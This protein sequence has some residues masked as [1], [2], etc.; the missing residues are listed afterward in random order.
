[1]ILDSFTQYKSIF[2]I[3]YSDAFEIWDRAGEIARRL[4]D[5]WP[6]LKVKEGQPQ[7]QVLG[8]EGVEIQTGFS[9]PTVTLSGAKA[10]EQRKVQQLKNTFEIWSELLKLDVLNRVST[11]VVFVKHFDSI[12]EANAAVFG[13]KLARW[14]DSKVFD[15]P[16]EADLN[17]LEIGYRFEDEQSF[18][19]LRIKAEQLSFEVDL[20]PYFLDEA[21]IKKTKNRM[22]IDFDR[23]L[24]GKVKV[25]NIR[26]DEWIKGFQHLLHRDIE[27]VLKGQG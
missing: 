11:R 20:D 17:G 14:P 7:I 19:L 24:L 8:G 4:S 2:Q 12:K 6:N 9:K 27:K 21:N 16:Q 15:Q 25:G 3:Q 1:M 18:S 22:V 23:G 5:V 26:V 13:L 10:F